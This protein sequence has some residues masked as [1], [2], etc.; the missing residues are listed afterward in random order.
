MAD[1][2]RLFSEL[3]DEIESL[4]GKYITKFIPAKPEDTP[5]VFEHD[6][7][8]FCILA[9]AGFEEFLELVSEAI[10]GGIAKDFL[11]RKLSLATVSLLLTYGEKISFTDDESKPAQ[12]CFDSIRISIDECKRKHAEALRENHGFAVKYMRRMLLPVG[13]N[14]PTD[15]VKLGSVR[16]LAD[17]R[18][19]FA[20][21]KA[22]NAM[23]GSYKKANNPLT[24]EDALNIVDDCLGLCEG[25]RD[26]AKSRW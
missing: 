24:P 12:S 16:K 23:Y 17:A 14:A 26:A 9:H 5:E 6:V 10:L 1:F 15:D 22:K 4:K 11:E 2:D 19:S 3:K 21:S 8:S 13:L 7:K 25:I 20:H 18:G